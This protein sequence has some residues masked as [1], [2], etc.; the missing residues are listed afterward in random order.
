MEVLDKLANKGITKCPF[1]LKNWSSFFLEI[2]FLNFFSKASI[3]D[4]ILFVS[5]LEKMGILERAKVLTKKMKFTQQS[6]LYLRMK[7]LL[8]PKYMGELF[9]VILAYKHNNNLTEYK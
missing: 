5:L 4:L 9:K 2:P 7:R 1:T 3:S 6:D 8:S